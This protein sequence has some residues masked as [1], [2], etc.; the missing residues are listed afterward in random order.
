MSRGKFLTK[1]LLELQGPIE[2]ED[3]SQWLVHFCRPTYWGKKLLTPFEALINILQTRRI[4]ASQEHIHDS[5]GAACFYEVPPHNWPELIKNDPNG[6]RGYGLIVSKSA[7]WYKG[8]RPCIYTDNLS[9]DYWPKEERYLLVYTNLNKDPN[10]I[11]WTH[12]R[13]W[14]IKGD[15][16]LEPIRDVTETWWYPCVE[17]LTD[18]QFIFREFYNIHYSYVIELDRTISKKQ[19]LI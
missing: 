6:R 15:F 9:E 18:A 5:K 4:I 8:G 17:K 2:K 7:F 10:P 19:L 14:R 3:F 1:E 13:E 16:T 12:E 11:D